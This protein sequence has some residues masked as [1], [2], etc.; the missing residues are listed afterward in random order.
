MNSVNKFATALS[1]TR[2]FSTG[3]VDAQSP[4]TVS[5]K[6]RGPEAQPARKVFQHVKKTGPSLWKLVKTRHLAIGHRFGQTTPCNSRNCKCCEMLTDLLQFSVNGL[7]VNVALGSCASY[8]IIYLI[9]CILP[10][11]KKCYTGRSVRAL[12][13]IMLHCTNIFINKGPDNSST[14]LDLCKQS[15]Q[16]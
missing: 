13:A 15:D 2:S 11:C 1:R 3:D 4:P 7:L 10:N 6:P 9:M 16:T 8:N 14:T 5:A 12:M